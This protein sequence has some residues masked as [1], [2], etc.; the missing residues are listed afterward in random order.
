MY[1]PIG[2]KIEEE[3]FVGESRTS[4]Y[5]RNKFGLIPRRKE[6]LWSFQWRE[7]RE[8][9]EEDGRKY[10]EEKELGRKRA[11]CRNAAPEMLEALMDIVSSIRAI[12]SN[13]PDLDLTGYLSREIEACETVIKKAGWMA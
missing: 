8:E 6:S 11:A 4:L 9:A 3:E 2:N 1:C 5:V 12:D 10:L 13:H 7:T